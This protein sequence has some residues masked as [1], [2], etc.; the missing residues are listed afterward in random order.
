[1]ILYEEPVKIT[2]HAQHRKHVR[3]SNDYFRWGDLSGT[4][5]SRGLA[6]L[7]ACV[8]PGHAGFGSSSE[9]PSESCFTLHQLLA[10]I[11]LPLSAKPA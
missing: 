5:A 2:T 11:L 3:E 4:S 7:V 8:S 9:W 10:Y 1:M 6:G